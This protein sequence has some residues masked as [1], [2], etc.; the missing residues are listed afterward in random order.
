[1]KNKKLSIDYD[2]YYAAA[3]FS[4]LSCPSYTVTL[5][6]V[7]CRN[8]SCVECM[9]LMTLFQEHISGKHSSHEEG[10]N[11]YFEL[12]E[13]QQAGYKQMVKWTL[14]CD[15]CD[16]KTTS[17]PQ[18]FDHIANHQ[19]CHLCSSSMCLHHRL[20]CLKTGLHDVI[21]YGFRKNCNSCCNQGCFIPPQV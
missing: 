9:C 8:T 17:K 13:W 10:S 1:M 11:M 14:E 7:N 16:Y 19:V 4:F 12:T 21:V 2:L 3:S 6:S 20:V 5:Q 15:R 18:M